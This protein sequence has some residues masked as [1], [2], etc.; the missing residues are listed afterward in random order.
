MRSTSIKAAGVEMSEI[1]IKYLC[2]FLM[3]NDNFE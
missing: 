3:M 2:C 1:F